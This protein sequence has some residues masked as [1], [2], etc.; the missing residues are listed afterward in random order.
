M[1]KVTLGRLEKVNL[2]DAWDDEANDFT[3]WLAEPENLKLLGQAIEIELELEAQEKSVGPFRAD[4]LCKDVNSDQWVLIENQLE[5]TNH[6]HLGQLLTYAAGL[7]AVTIIWIAEIFRDEHRAALDWLNTITNENIN[8][9]GLEIELWRIANSPMAPKFNVISQPNNWSKTVS[10]GTRN[11]ETSEY[12]EAKQLQLEYWTQLKSL[13]QEQNSSVRIGTPQRQSWMNFHV[14]SRQHFKL[15]ASIDTR[16]KKIWVGLVLEG[17]DSKAHYHLLQRDKEAIENEI[18]ANLDWRE[19]PN[20]TESQLYI[21][22]PE[23]MDPTIREQWP[24]QHEWMREK[25]E[26]LKTVFS[27]RVQQLKASQYKPEESIPVE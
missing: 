22:A 2:R 9:F 5:R 17:P 3:P 4:I 11:I 19:N 21:Y 20:K 6:P 13:L 10:E 7:N 27:P 16:K 15:I 26:R 12:S 25:L 8:F 24:E 18:G 14:L 1:S 23:E